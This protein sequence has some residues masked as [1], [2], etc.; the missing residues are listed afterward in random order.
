MIVLADKD[1]TL[2]KLQANEDVYTVLRDPDRKLRGYQNTLAAIRDNNNELLKVRKHPW[3]L[4]WYP[5]IFR[6]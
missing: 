4:G 1:S 2:V 3:W 6:R 5:R